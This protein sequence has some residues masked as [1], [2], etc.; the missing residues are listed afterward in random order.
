MMT[1][2][3]VCVFVTADGKS[4]PPFSLIIFIL[5]SFIE[6]FFQYRYVRNPLHFLFLWKKVCFAVHN[7]MCI[8]FIFC[9]KKIQIFSFL[10]VRG[11]LHY[12]N[13]IFFT[14]NVLYACMF[15]LWNVFLKATKTTSLSSPILYIWKN[16]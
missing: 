10:Y 13:S 16:N 11:Y 15:S 1:P 9:G 6:F 5:N 7:V 3:N 2:P 12:K 4:P 14:Q 8:F